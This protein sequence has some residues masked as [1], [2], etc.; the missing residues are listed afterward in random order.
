M[1]A[2]MQ[3][4]RMEQIDVGEVQLHR[5]VFKDRSDPCASLSE[6]EYIQLYRLSKKYERSLLEKIRVILHRALD[7][8][9]TFLM[10]CVMTFY[11]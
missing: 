7:G 5:G 3:M 2:L 6:E 11:I 1:E 8:R 4:N 10:R 9:G